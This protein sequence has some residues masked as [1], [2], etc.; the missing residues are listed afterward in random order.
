MAARALVLLLPAALIVNSLVV[1][2]LGLLVERDLAVNGRL[3]VAQI[4]GEKTT[5]DKRRRPMPWL[6]LRYQI[7]GKSY[8]TWV[9]RPKE[10]KVGLLAPARYSP[11]CPSHAVLATT[12]PPAWDQSL[13]LRIAAHA[14]VAVIS[15]GLLIGLWRRS[16]RKGS[17]S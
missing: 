5:L 1:F 14:S 4:A 17:P 13:G 11:M 10:L 6:L 3:V 12:P 16:R 8:E 2:P 7:E 15:A 9:L